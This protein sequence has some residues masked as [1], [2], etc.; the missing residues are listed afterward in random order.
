[1]R[2]VGYLKR[3]PSHWL[4]SDSFVLYFVFIFIKDAFVCVAVSDY[5]EELKWK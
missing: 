3:L 5:R 2:L 1:V 4:F